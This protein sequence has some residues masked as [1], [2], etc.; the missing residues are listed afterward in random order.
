MR[1]GFAGLG[2]MGLPMARNL[3]HAGIGQVSVWNR[4][5]TRCQ[6]LG[7]LGARVAGTPAQLGRNC[8]I[9]ITML[10]DA[11]ALEE[12]LTGSAGIL[13]DTKPGCL[14][15][16]MSTIGPVAAGRFAGLAAAHGAGFLDAPVSGSVPV[17][18][19]AALLTMVGG[20]AAQFEQAR[21]ALQA[22]TAKQVHLGPVGTGAAM[23]IALNT[24]IAATNQAVAEVLLLSSNLG[25]SA[26]RAYDVLQHSVVSSPFVNYK[27]DAFLAPAD[28]PVAFTIDL[29]RKD[30]AL[31]LGLAR[32]Q[33][34]ALPGTATNEAVL[35]AASAQGLG[36]ADMARVLAALDRPAAVRGEDPGTDIA[37]PAGLPPI[38]DDTE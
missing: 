7:D 9:I 18:E 32:D 8:D 35:G 21:P 17:A 4:T 10:A 13:V 28:Q 11:A 12:V 2:R 37:W 24:M 31:A 36:R 25:V 3:L 29:L 6:A 33:H 20:S 22:M 16:D 26:E 5:S 23:K 30:L 19:S 27:R 15:V 34:I 14:I 38:W 1:L